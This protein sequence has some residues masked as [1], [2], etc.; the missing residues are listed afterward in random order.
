MPEASH[1]APIALP[2]KLVSHQEKAPKVVPDATSLQAEENAAVKA[3][4]KPIVKPTA[5]PSPK[6]T[7]KPQST[8]AP[9]DPKAIL[10]GTSTGKTVEVKSV[11]PKSDKS[12][13][14]YIQIGAYA[15]ESKAL[16]TLKKLTDAGIPAR[17]EKVTTP[18]GELTRVRIGPG[19]DE[20]KAKAWLQRL[21]ALGVPGKLI[22]QAAP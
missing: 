8:K 3:T 5:K 10:E 14:Y 18:K 22:V 17:S 15:D 20:A 21:D 6:P 13:L 9:A 19:H 7:L 2:G 1:V 4:A 12:N 11:E 16:Q